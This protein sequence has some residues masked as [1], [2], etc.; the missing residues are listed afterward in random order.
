MQVL[1]PDT[2]NEVRVIYDESERM[3]EDE[4]YDVCVA[5]PDLRIERNAQGELIIVAPAGAESDSRNVELVY[6][7]AAWAKRDRGG[8]V[9][10]PSAEFML[11]DGSGYSPDA[12]WVS[13]AQL[14]TF[15]RSQRRKFL[16]LAPEFVA[17]IMS[18]SDRLRTAQ[19]KMAGWMRN[20]VKL[21]W[22]IDADHQTVYVYG[23]GSARAR[24]HTGI[25]K[26]A[27]EGPLTGFELELTDIWAG[28]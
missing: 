13:N 19:A 4:F 23:A 15:T 8:R 3:N 28:L 14:A 5:N 25:R 26:L 12:A 17:E 11:P 10:G 22:L 16:G 27:G 20:G 6:Q 9:F 1:L 24:K 7:L 18:P 2:V 21:G